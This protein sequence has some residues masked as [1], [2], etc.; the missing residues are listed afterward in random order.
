[1]ID[2]MYE[3]KIK[4]AYLPIEQED[5]YRI[6]VD[7]IWPRGVSKEQIKLYAWKKEIAPSTQLRKW[8]GHQKERYIEFTKKY[9]EELDCNKN[10]LEFINECKKLLKG[11]HVTF[12]FAAHDCECNNA[13]VLKDWVMKHIIG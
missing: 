6:L 10:S 12:L 9:N 2:V 5:G 13:A 11:N 7:R 4:R 3:L 8:F 1:M